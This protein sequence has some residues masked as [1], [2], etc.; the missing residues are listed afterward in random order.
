MRDVAVT[1][2]SPRTERRPA[3]L[4]DVFVL[5]L[6]KRDGWPGVA[7]RLEDAHGGGWKFLQFICGPNWTRLEATPTIR[8]A[9]AQRRLR[10]AAEMYKNSEL[11]SNGYV[12]KFDRDETE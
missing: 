11:G 5:P 12:V 6:A 9:P 8:T 2:G 7:V 3:S 1:C 4:A 10:T